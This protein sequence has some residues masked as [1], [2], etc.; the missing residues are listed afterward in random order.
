MIKPDTKLSIEIV[1][2]SHHCGDGCCFEYG[3]Y[4]VVNGKPINDDEYNAITPD[5]AL[6]AMLSYLGYNN[7][8]VEFSEEEEDD[9]N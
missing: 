5:K 2:W 1:E 9:E 3:A 4:L 6:A 8:E 7:F